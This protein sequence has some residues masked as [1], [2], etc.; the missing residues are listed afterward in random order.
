MVQFQKLTRNVFFSYTGT[1]CTVSS[2]SCPSF[3]CATSSWLLILTA[4]PRG[5]FPRW[6]RSRKRLCVCSG[7]RCPDL[8][9]Q[10]SMSFVHNL[11]LLVALS[12]TYTHGPTYTHVPSICPKRQSKLDDPTS[13]NK[14]EQHTPLKA[15]N[16][17]NLS[18]ISVNTNSA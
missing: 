13:C 18:L 2:G 1:M 12:P 8:W 11:V 14:P 5:Q 9:L 17:F 6:H 7:L 15:E 16:L 10:C 3:S 4:G